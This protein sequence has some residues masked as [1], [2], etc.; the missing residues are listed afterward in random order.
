MMAGSIK[1]N[2][3][4]GGAREEDDGWQREVEGGR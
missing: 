3:K 4:L 2:K 1:E